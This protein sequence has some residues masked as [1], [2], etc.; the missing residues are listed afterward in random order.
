MEKEEGNESTDPN[1][2]DV[3]C[4]ICADSKE[5]REM[6]RISNGC[7]HTFCSD[8]ISK[9][10]LEKVCENATVIKCPGLE[11]VGVLEIED[12]RGI[13]SEDL[14]IRWERARCEAMF[15][16]SQKLYCPFK[17]CSEM[18]IKDWD[19]GEKDMDVKVRECECPCCHRLFCAD[20]EV[21]WHA[22]VTCEDYQALDE[23]ERGREDLMVR[24]LALENKWGRCPRCKYYVERTQ[25]CPHITCRCQF[26]FCYG[27]GATWDDKHGGCTRD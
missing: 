11:C 15:L 10:I 14:A 18:L 24:E 8:C 16:D 13:V 2:V 26:Q 1:P 20:C 25:G 3:F 6:F 23:D 9:H 12:C 22:G 17:D 7:S 5:Q 21:P 27:C 4:E 19:N